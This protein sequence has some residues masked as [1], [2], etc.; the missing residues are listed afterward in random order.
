MPD[1]TLQETMDRIELLVRAGYPVIY[2]VSHEEGRVLE[3]LTRLY[4]VIKGEKGNKALFHWTAEGLSE[5]TGLKGHPRASSRVWLKTPGWDATATVQSRGKVKAED[6]EA[7]IRSA[8]D[9][10]DNLKAANAINR[11]AALDSIAV[12]LDLHQDLWTDASGNAGSLVRP[13]RNTAEALRRYYEENAAEARRRSDEEKA[14]AALRPSEDTNEAK[15]EAEDKRTRHAFKTIFVVAP[16][17]ARLSMELEHDVIVVDF[18]LPETDE[19]AMALDTMLA[20]GVLTF[21]EDANAEHKTRL[22]ELIAGAGRGLALED[23]KLGLNMFS[24]RDEPLSE[25]HVEDLLQL[26][27]KAINND[28]LLYTPHVD[29]QLGGLKNIRKWL[30][31]RREPTISPEVRKSFHLPETK[32]VMLCGVS[33]GGKSQ[34]AKLIANEFNVAL[35]RLDVGALFGMYVGESEERTRRALRL[36]EVLSPV[37]LWLD[38]VDKAFK[39]M[40]GDGDN[41]VSARVFGHFLTWLAEKKDNV[42]VVATAND[43]EELLDKFPEFGRKG[44]FDEIFWVDL[45]SEE[46]SADIFKIYLAPLVGDGYLALTEADVDELDGGR[47]TLCDDDVEP[48]DRALVRFS[49]LLAAHSHPMTGAEIEYAV[50]QALY[51]AYQLTH[52]NGGGGAIGF[53]PQLIISI[54]DDAA[55]RAL[56]NQGSDDEKRLQKLRHMAV[57]E[58][59]WINAE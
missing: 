24:V 10:L 41:G 23:Y 2:V 32:G 7:R 21:P 56:Y 20:S 35:L 33:G 29:V 55:K 1:V 17:A 37:V 34:L 39:G 13:L 57:G 59:K 47:E 18:P 4:R 52:Q 16:S 22:R 25:R 53:T 19:L 28:A 5:V 50:S 43:F 45:P 36:A 11:P 27:A 9:A 48:K 6:P 44:R 26:K 12:F 58:R 51:Q 46:G 8:T 31:I 30:A 40:G 15:G 42:F 14:A 38:E 54:V 3:Y 49:K